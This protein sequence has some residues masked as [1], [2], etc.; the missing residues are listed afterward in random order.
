MSTIWRSESDNESDNE[1]DSESE[2]DE[3]ANVDKVY[4]NWKLT[5]P[6]LLLEKDIE[7]VKKIIKILDGEC[8]ANNCDS[9]GDSYGHRDEDSGDVKYDSVDEAYKNWVHTRPGVDFES[10]EAI[11]IIKLLDGYEKCYCTFCDWN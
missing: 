7:K 1:S 4:N 2:Y 6:D 3:Y 10:E 11:R 8:Y 5:R 9:D